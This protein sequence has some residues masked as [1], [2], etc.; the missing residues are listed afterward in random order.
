MDGK[1]TV[2]HV[3]SETSSGNEK[4]FVD[5]SLGDVDINNNTD[6]KYV[7][8]ILPTKTVRPH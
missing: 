6:A 8:I 4:R 7:F 3:D 5:E 1:D 2:H